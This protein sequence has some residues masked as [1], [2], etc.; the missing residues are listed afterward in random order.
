MASDATRETTPA[1]RSTRPELATQLSPGHVS[2]LYELAAA[3]LGPVQIA[4]RLKAGATTLDGARLRPVV[5]SPEAVRS[6]LRS[7]V[8]QQR[9]AAARAE[10]FGDAL[11][12]SALAW[13]GARV[14]E[15]EAL[16]RRAAAMTADRSAAPSLRLQASAEARQLLGQ[17]ES[18]LAPLIATATAT[19]SSDGHGGGGATVTVQQRLG[20]GQGSDSR[21]ASLL[22]E[23]L[24][25][26]AQLPATATEI[27]TEKTTP[28][29]RKRS[30]QADQD[31]GAATEAESSQLQP[32]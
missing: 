13:P 23:V 1:T 21:R 28:P 11:A 5:V 26:M 3:G 30:T 17:I 10:M 14:V 31:A 16:Y 27:A 19:A 8:G 20:P 18:V 29:P 7:K 15:L 6:R 9:L 4:G 24:A 22:R 2:I 25:R 32:D 12:V